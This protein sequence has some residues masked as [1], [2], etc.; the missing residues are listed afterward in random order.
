MKKVYTSPEVTIF[1]L[2]CEE[3]MCLVTSGTT[4]EEIE[5][6]TGEW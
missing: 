4:V 2:S 5:Y 6:V 3:Q 1:E